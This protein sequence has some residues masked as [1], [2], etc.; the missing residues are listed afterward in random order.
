MLQTTKSGRRMGRTSAIF[1]ADRLA[2]NFQRLWKQMGGTQQGLGLSVGKKKIAE[3]TE[4]RWEHSKSKL[5]N[6]IAHAGF[7]ASTV[8]LGVVASLWFFP[9]DPSGLPLQWMFYWPLASVLLVVAASGTAVYIRFSA[10][11]KALHPMPKSSA[12]EP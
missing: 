7:I 12:A 11:S 9:G 5:S 3:S 2:D 6:I 8:A 1:K 4:S 10:S